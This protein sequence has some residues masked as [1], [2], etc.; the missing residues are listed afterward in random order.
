MT[1]H[2]AL[3]V[4]AVLSLASCSGAPAAPT[5]AP[6]TPPPP[7]LPICQTQNTASLTLTNLAAQSRIVFIDGVS[8]SILAPNGSVMVTVVAGVAHP[9]SFRDDR[10]NRE[11]STANP[12][13]VVCSTFTITNSF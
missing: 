3:V 10:T 8:R 6:V 1:K 2:F 12:V 11:V 7:S 5:P 4:V 13:L 9:I